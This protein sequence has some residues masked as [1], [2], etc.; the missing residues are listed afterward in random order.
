MSWTR[1]F[2]RRNLCSRQTSAPPHN[3]R[4]LRINTRSPRVSARPG[5]PTRRRVCSTRT[6]RL[7]LTRS[8]V[9][10]GHPPPRKRLQWTWPRTTV[11]RSTR[12]YRRPGPMIT[13]SRNR[14]QADSSNLCTR[15]LRRAPDFPYPMEA[16]TRMKNSGRDTSRSSKRL[17]WGRSRNVRLKMNRSTSQ[18]LNLSRILSE[19]M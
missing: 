16:M 15:L 18:I 12:D 3:P 10:L 9:W 2:R 17:N 5:K 13:C 8:W 6:Q 4:N 11:S 19:K 7:S 1:G 14:R